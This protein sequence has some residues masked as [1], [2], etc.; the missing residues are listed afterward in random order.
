MKTRLVAVLMLMSVFAFSQE[1]ETKMWTINGKVGVNTSQ[2]GFY[3]WAQ[4]GQNSIAGLGFFQ[5]NA[6]MKKDN[7]TWDNKLDLEYGLMQNE[8]EIV[9]KSDDRIELDSCVGRQ[10]SG[11]WYYS[12]FL[13]FK[14]Q[15]T[16]GFDYTKNDTVAISTFMAPAYLTF[17]LG[18]DYKPVDYFSATISP[19]SSKITFVMDDVLSDAGSFGVDPA[20]YDS[21][22]K[23]V[24][25]GKKVRFE[26]GATA[27]LLFKKDILKNV[28]LMSKLD[29]F[30]NYLKNPQNI[31][32]SW[33]NVI[34]M[35]INS[36][37][38]AM[39]KTHLIY[40]DD[41]DIAREVDGVMHLGP[42]VQ[43]KQSIAV[44][45]MYQF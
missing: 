12:G 15:F 18:M 20:E 1:E 11:H 14:T 24:K 26:L 13:N 17:G 37:L 16:D 42:A 29:L 45:L 34:T 22:G 40:D 23:K 6:N 27:T 44:G 5:L 33:E 36:Y 19:I 10:A 9:K 7:W 41:V 35:K 31:D 2:V 21:M 32:V 38:N 8:G 43:F 28:N 25:D 3:N 4:G 30:S 39:I